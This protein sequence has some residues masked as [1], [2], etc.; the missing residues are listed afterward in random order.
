MHKKTLDK[1]LLFMK[2]EIEKSG[3]KIELFTFDFSP[4]E[5][6]KYVN[7]PDELKPEGEDLVAFKKISKI[8][9]TVEIMKVIRR[10]L[11]DEYMKVG[12]NN[13]TA[14]KLTQRGVARIDAIKYKQELV[15]TRLLKYIADKLLIPIVVAVIVA[16]LVNYL[17][18]AR[19]N[20]DIENLKG[21][22]QWLKSQHKSH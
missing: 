2:H 4:E 13:F 12:N 17:T 1:L 11:T 7:A 6:I 9:D 15:F 14:V 8:K 22:T 16:I 5:T 21:E 19:L 20:N 10:A 3:R 18:G